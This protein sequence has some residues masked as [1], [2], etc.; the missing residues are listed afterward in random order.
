MLVKRRVVMILKTLILNAVNISKSIGVRLTMKTTGITMYKG[1]HVKKKR[2]SKNNV[3]IKKHI[4]LLKK[5]ESKKKIERKSITVI[6]LLISF[7]ILIMLS[8]PVLK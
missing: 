2:T 4:S 3:Y 7:I 8:F 5:K 1:K 6:P